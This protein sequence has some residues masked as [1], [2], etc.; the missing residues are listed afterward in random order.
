MAANLTDVDAISRTATQVISDALRFVDYG[1]GDRLHVLSTLQ[2]LLRNFTALRDSGTWQDRGDL[3]Q[4]RSI[5][6]RIANNDY[7]HVANNDNSSNSHVEVESDDGDADLSSPPSKVRTGRVGAPAYYISNE[8]LQRFAD[9][10]HSMQEAADALNVDRSTIWRRA[11]AAG[12]V[13]NKGRNLSTEQV[14]Q[15]VLD[16]KSRF[17]DWGIDNTRSAIHA[18]FGV[19]VSRRK[20][21]DSLR[22]HDPFGVAARWSRKLKRRVYSV[23][24]PNSLWHFDTNHK[25]SIC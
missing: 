3:N 17:P 6:D 16:I 8:Q 5:I 18:T 9:S 11:T 20:V 15:Y 22:R 23:P 10:G 24:G 12:V 7:Q 13:F 1:I 19:S 14:D 4:L 21:A 2:Q 25:V